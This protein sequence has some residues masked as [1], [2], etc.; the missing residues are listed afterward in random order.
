L[1]YRAG[2][3]CN[4]EQ[5]VKYIEN[6]NT[7]AEKTER[8]YKRRVVISFDACQPPRD[9]RRQRTSLIHQALANKGI[10]LLDGD[11]ASKRP[12]MN[13]FGDKVQTERTVVKTLRFGRARIVLP[14]S[15][16]MGETQDIQA[17]LERQY[18]T[19]TLDEDET[20]SDAI[21]H[22]IK[23]SKQCFT[24][25]SVLYDDVDYAEHD[26]KAVTIPDSDVQCKVQV[27]VGQFNTHF[28]C[29]VDVI[30]ETDGVKRQAAL[31][32]HLTDIPEAFIAAAQAAFTVA[33]AQHG[34]DV[35]EPTFDC[36]FTANIET[37]SKCEP[38]IIRQMEKARLQR[39]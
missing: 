35:S 26:A 13:S 5:V 32:T 30:W 15:V 23:G 27:D 8:I 21:V 22:Q 38:D 18:K 37:V 9:E 39:L 12:N 2:I 17:Q 6:E 4:T 36:E 1:C 19:V 34:V 3:R 16:T 20:R 25:L 7:Q 31:K 10:M 24:A 28:T 11:W 29:T 33:L 14:S